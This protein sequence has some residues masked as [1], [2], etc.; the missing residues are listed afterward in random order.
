MKFCDIDPFIR[1]AQFITITSSRQYT[2]IA[3]YDYRLFYCNGGSGIITVD[4]KTFEMKEGSLISWPPGFK[5]SLLPIENKSLKLIQVNFDYTKNNRNLNKPIGPHKWRVFNSDNIVEKVSF[6]DMPEFN[7][8]IFIA[9][10]H[11]ISRSMYNIVTEFIAK[12]DY[13]DLRAA[14]LLQ[15]NLALIARFKKTES[16]PHKND[17]LATEVIQYIHTHYHKN[18]SNNSLGEHFG[19][20]PNHLNR[21]IVQHT[22]MSIHKYLINCRIEAAIDLIQASD[23]KT[24]E[25]AEIVGFSDSTH[26]LKYF[27][28]FT[29]KNTKDYRQ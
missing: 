15:N 23:L 26:F 9:D 1:Y 20:H 14:G 16:T 11:F 7:S 5:Y 4:G 18:I 29:G 27:K 8:P 19:Y 2:N 17:K 21:L 25:I 28:K 22:G 24:S 12:K 3:P 6:D 13:F 10:M